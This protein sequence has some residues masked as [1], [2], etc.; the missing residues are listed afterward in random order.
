MEKVTLVA[1]K[2]R[3]QRLMSTSKETSLKFTA[4]EKRYREGQR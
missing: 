4:A 3:L 2:D 1:V